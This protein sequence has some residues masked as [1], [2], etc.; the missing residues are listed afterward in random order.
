[1][2]R[3]KPAGQDDAAKKKPAPAVSGGGR[4][5]P[6]VAGTSSQPSPDS[7]RRTSTTTKAEE[8]SLKPG[9]RRRSGVSQLNRDEDLENPFES[10]TTGAKKKQ[11]GLV[12]PESELGR[13]LSIRR[14]ST[15]DADVSA[16]TGPLA[17]KARAEKVKE[18]EEELGRSDG[19]LDLADALSPSALQG[20][21]LSD[22]PEPED[23]M[24]RPRGAAEVQDASFCCEDEHVSSVIDTALKNYTVSNPLR[25]GNPLVFASASFLSLTGHTQSELVGRNCNVLQAGETDQPG[26]ETLRKGLDKLQ[27]VRVELKNYKADKT[28]FW[29]LLYVY[30]IVDEENK[31]LNFAGVTFDVSDRKKRGD[32][33]LGDPKTAKMQEMLDRMHTAYGLLDM[34]KKMGPISYVNKEFEALTGFKT[35]ALLGLGVLCL[36]GPESDHKKMKE[37]LSALH[38]KQRFQ[39]S[40][41]CYKQDG[42]PFWAYLNL[43][44]MMDAVTSAGSTHS[45]LFSLC[46]VTS[47]KNDRVGGYTLGRVVGKGAS[48]TVH[49]GKKDSKSAKA[50][51]AAEPEKVAVKVIDTSQFQSISEID[52][53]QAEIQI[54]ERL[55]HPNVVRMLEVLYHNSK[56]Y[57]IM[58]YA[59]GGSLMK[60]IYNNEARRLDEKEAWRCFDQMLDALNYCHRRRIY[61]RDLKPENI[62]MD[63]D[64]NIKIAD[65]GLSTIVSAFESGASESVGTPEFC[66]PEIVNGVEYE[67]DKVDIWSLGVILFELVAGYLPFQ[68]NTEKGLCDLIV[69]AKYSF[70]N[71]FSE[72]LKSL[73]R[74]MLDV[75][76]LTRITIDEMLKMPW[77]VQGIPEDQKRKFHEDDAMRDTQL[78]RTD[79]SLDKDEVHSSATL[80]MSSL[81][82]KVLLGIGQ[83]TPAAAKEEEAAKEAETS[84]SKA[85]PAA[86]HKAAVT[87]SRKTLR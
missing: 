34:S 22:T 63:S 30:P 24:V 54:L 26:V 42:T 59:A 73:I 83:S 38:H 25:A 10:R 37:V 9:N 58:E 64:M 57:I 18:S 46:D 69:K 28:E 23:E 11:A 78:N 31:L 68:H 35:P 56:I 27:P 82:P 12:A 8:A 72:E 45:M 85:K 7:R 80:D 44:P 67:G 74:R 13:K 14:A 50:H 87:T 4:I 75:D 76:Q 61:H 1:M 47:R 71:F 29:N 5:K 62:L 17:A 16:R 55:N 36:A 49:I 20:L 77:Y 51:K 33:V 32:D 65:F 53:V 21:V 40:L 66:P 79:S 2:Q 48:G 43:V 86:G 81:D 52:T 3:A 15:M 19:E 84:S 41:L 6:P 70:P 60:Y 39:G